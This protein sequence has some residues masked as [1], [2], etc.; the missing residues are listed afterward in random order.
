MDSSFDPY[1]KWLGIPREEQ[2]PN[3]YRLLGIKVFEDDPDVISNSADRQMGHVRSFQ[4]GKHSALSQQ[5]LNELSNARVCLLDPEK[6]KAY[7]QRLRSEMALAAE[8][9]SPE[10]PGF[11]YHLLGA[12]RYFAVEA[13]RLWLAEVRLPAAYRALGLEIDQKNFYG[14]HLKPLHERLQQSRDELA[15]LRQKMAEQPTDQGFG[16][17]IKQWIEWLRARLRASRSVYQNRKCLMEIG[18]E[19]YRAED[20]AIQGLDH[21]TPI[22]ETLE[23]LGHLSTDAARL[24]QVP[25]NQLLSPKRLAWIIVGIVGGFWLLV[26]WLRW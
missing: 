6:R 13:R 2:P 1:R 3:L 15:R 11:G 20:P 14:E 8:T 9:W 17:K 21:L 19:A 24:S 4:A 26:T 16:A 23:R 12:A 25:P 7:D 10:G 22:R 18:R 5:L